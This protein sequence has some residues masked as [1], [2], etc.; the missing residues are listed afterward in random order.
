MF[1]N[2][3]LTIDP[4]FHDGDGYIVLSSYNE[5]GRPNG[6]VTHRVDP[7]G[8]RYSGNYF[9]P[10]ENTPEAVMEALENARS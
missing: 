2:I 10:R 8:A 4:K 5:N 1:S 7:E 6:F 3:L 9:P